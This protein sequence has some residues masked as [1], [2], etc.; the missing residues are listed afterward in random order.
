MSVRRGDQRPHSGGCSR[1]LPKLARLIRSAHGP[2]SHGDPD[3]PSSAWQAARLVP[4]ARPAVPAARARRRH[5]I[6]EHLQR[7]HR[8]AARAHG[9]SL[10][11]RRDAPRLRA[12]SLR[13]AVA[14][15][16]PAQL[17]QPAAVHRRPAPADLPGVLRRADRRR[18]AALR[19]HRRTS[20]RSVHRLPSRADRARSRR[21][22]AHDRAD[23]EELDRGPGSR[24]TAAS[25][26]PDSGWSA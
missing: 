8:S 2:R 20:A 21:S 17:P 4:R 25:T 1:R 23:M 6:P 18:R 24:A 19:D 13:P 10:R 12:I 16:V 7:G 11:A 22:P 5:R 14:D 3:L 15:D 26:S 9:G